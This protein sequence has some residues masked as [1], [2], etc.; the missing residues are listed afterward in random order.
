MDVVSVGGLVTFKI[1][2]V[3]LVTRH[4]LNLSPSSTS[5]HVFEGLGESTIQ[6]RELLL[7]GMG[8]SKGHLEEVTTSVFVDGVLYEVFGEV[9]LD[10]LVS[11]DSTGVS[12]TKDLSWGWWVGFW[13]YPLSTG[14]DSGIC[15]NIPR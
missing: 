10:G 2:I 1:V 12:S 5:L 11:T 15:E 9:F 8:Y 14:L 3:I 4:S 6:V 13:V 7:F